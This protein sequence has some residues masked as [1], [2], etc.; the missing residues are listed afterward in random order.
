MPEKGYIQLDSAM[1]YSFIYP[2]YARVETDVSPTA[3]PNWINIT[4]PQFNAKIHITYIE[5]N[6]NIYE[7]IEDNIRFAYAH[8]IK[9]DGIKEYPFINDNQNVYG[10][11][12]EIK[13]NAA[14]SFQFF[15]T[16]SVRHF[17]RGA[18]Y[19]NTAP[20]K[21]SLAP[22]VH[23]ISDDIFRMVESIRWKNNW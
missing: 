18:L 15:V 7:I 4:F 3:E 16:D 17:L 8:T 13:G 22:V 6:N 11:V 5:V 1:P 14:S 20:N 2:K 19:F 10:T 23:F 12:F 21:D 9:A